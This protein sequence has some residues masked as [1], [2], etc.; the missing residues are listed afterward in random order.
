[1]II[2][3]ARLVG[4][5][6]TAA[7]L[8]SVAAA[9]DFARL[10]SDIADQLRAAAVPG[11]S[12]AVVVD[13]R[14]VWAKG[15]G[16]AEAGTERR[17][18]ESTLFQA[19]SISKPVA[20]FGVLR[21][22][23]DQACDLDQTVDR[24]LKS[25]TFPA[26]TTVTLRQL[27]SHTSGLSVHGFGG[28]QHGRDIPTLQQI[29]LGQRPANSGVISLQGLPGKRFKYSGGGYCVVQQVVIDVTGKSFPEAMRSLVTLPLDMN[30][31][32]YR[33]PLPVD[34]VATAAT[35]HD[36]A[37]RPIEGRYRVY[38]EMAAA[39]LWTTATDMARFII[40]I[41]SAYSGAQGKLNK[42][43][44]QEMLTA[45]VTDGP[46]LGL[47]LSGD[48]RTGS[49]HHGGVNNGFKCMIAATKH[50]GN[51]LVIM[52]NSDNGDKVY[53]GIQKAVRTALSQK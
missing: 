47:F 50:P 20:A 42:Q 26:A 39:G 6:I 52:T 45:Q 13:N 7:F 3:N 17:V 46:G 33:Q 29:L 4:V 18:T 8:S 10:E 43:L 28:Y 2:Q 53:E 23:Q 5:L 35:A 36:S 44:A 24:Y 25:A 15:I 40:A 12:V 21:L 38:P 31:S 1:M 22:V 37:S 32:T 19:A 34:L 30:D 27:L 11:A 49:F 9:Q 51:G 16:L 41:Q 14:I 48:D